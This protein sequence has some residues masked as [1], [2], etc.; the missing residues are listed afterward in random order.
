MY[1]LSPKTFKVR[2]SYKIHIIMGSM[3]HNPYFY[4][5]KFKHKRNLL[6][7]RPYKSLAWEPIQRDCCWVW[8]LSLLPLIY[9]KVIRKG[10]SRSMR[11]PKPGD[12]DWRRKSE[13]MTES[14]NKG[15]GVYIIYRTEQRLAKRRKKE[16]S[17][18]EK[19]FDIRKAQ[20]REF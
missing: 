8:N 17:I 11:I 5:V 15:L 13:A 18:N 7:L 10:Q 19:T 16:N 2:N 4:T 20:G 6:V 9:K 3:K 12:D 14:S 1:Y